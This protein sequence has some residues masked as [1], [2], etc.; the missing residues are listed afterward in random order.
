MFTGLIQTVGTLK[1]TTPRGNYRVLSIQAR[2]EDEPL[3]IGESIACDGVC[4]TVTSF[5]DSSFE[6]DASQES[7]SKTI[8]GGY[9]TG[10]KI[11]LE[12]AIRAGE[13]MGGHIVTGHIDDTGTVDVVKSVGES[14]MLA[15]SFDSRYDNLVIDKGSVAIDGVSLTINETKPGW[16]SVNIIPH[17]ADGTNLGTLKKGDRVNLEFDIIGKYVEKMVS[18]ENKGNLTIE[19]LRES[20]W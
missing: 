6:V 13:R 20:G 3:V 9:R 7:L 5:K 2:F 10:A 8:I 12:R 14:L 18:K 16:L 11:N 1:N 15:V 19:K 17:T 4:L